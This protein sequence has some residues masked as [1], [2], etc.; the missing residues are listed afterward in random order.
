MDDLETTVLL[1]GFLF[2]EGPR[3]REGR[4]WFSDMWGG[5]V[6]SV[7]LAGNMAHIAEFDHPSGLGFMP[8]GSLLVS[9]MYERRIYRIRGEKTEVHA[10]LT[11]IAHEMTNDM[12]VDDE[13]RAYIDTDLKNVVLVE[14]DG[15]SRLVAEGMS[16]PNG[17][18]ITP[19]GETLIVNETRGEAIRAFPIQ[20][21][22]SLG[23]PRL[24]ADL[25]G[26]FPDG[27]CLDEEGAVWIGS[28][29]L[30]AEQYGDGQFLRVLEGGEVTDRISTPGRWAI[31]PMLG[32]PD[33]KTLFLTTSSVENVKI[34]KETGKAEDGRIETVRVDVPGAGLP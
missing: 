25:P 29:P 4:L 11:H 2:G 5:Q 24:F 18:A 12:V 13:G 1:S 30:D 33:R 34:L 7:D 6:M 31:A 23:T 14:P 32:G 27:L 15:R 9:V 20:Q 28:P 10:D 21:D 22:G 8:D 19:D 3:W 26:T 16:G 17:L